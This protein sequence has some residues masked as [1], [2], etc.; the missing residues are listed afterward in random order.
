VKSTL[1]KL[2][3]GESD[4]ERVAVGMFKIEALID[5]ESYYALKPI[6]EDQT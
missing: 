2:F 4:R 3:K 1:K 5:V 6:G